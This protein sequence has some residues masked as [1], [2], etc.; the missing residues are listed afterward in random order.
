MLYILGPLSVHGRNW[1][2]LG[3]Y[4]LGELLMK[5]MDMGR[6]ATMR[7]TSGN[8]YI[9]GGP[10]RVVNQQQVLVSQISNKE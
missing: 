3:V 10:V 8:E 9:E 6:R 2:Q 5:V 4:G 7:V 1:T